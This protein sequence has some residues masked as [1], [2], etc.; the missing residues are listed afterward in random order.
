[1][2]RELENFREFFTAKA[3]SL[4]DDGPTL[5]VL[6]V[7]SPAFPIDRKRLEGIDTTGIQLTLSK[8][9]WGTELMWAAVKQMRIG[10]EEP[11]IV[12]GDLNSSEIFDT[13]WS[14]G[15]RGNREIM[16][17][18]NALGFHDCLRTFKGKLTPTFRSPRR[19][20]VVH[21]LDHMYVTPMLLSRL[22]SC[23]VGSAKRVFEPRPMLSDHLP[24]IADFVRPD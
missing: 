7:Y 18:M 19:G 16:A 12:A 6:S 14:G 17:R 9:V 2:D 4:H 21:Q 10:P 13:M 23:E 24:I 8:D 15:P 20:S 5:S 1:M 11:F 22:V 3:V